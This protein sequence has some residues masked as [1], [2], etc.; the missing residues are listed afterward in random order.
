MK[1]KTP[2]IDEKKL[3]EEFNKTLK[4]NTKIA[5]YVIGKMSKNHKN[6]KNQDEL[7]NK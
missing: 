1:P 2:K 3:Q 7:E 4:I 5:K 6:F